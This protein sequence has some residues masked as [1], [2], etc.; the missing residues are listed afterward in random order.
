MNSMYGRVPV[1]N[2]SLLGRIA[3]VAKCGPAYQ[4][5]RSS[6]SVCV[7]VR[8]CVRACVCVCCVSVCLFLHDREPY[9]NDL[10]DRDAVWRQAGVGSRNHVLDKVYS[11]ATWRIRLN[12]P[13]VAL[14]RPYVK[15]I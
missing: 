12:D 14:T 9:E 2:L 3:A 11:G 5:R 13:S 4:L 10:A 6:V 7:C 1:Q 8:A 15:L